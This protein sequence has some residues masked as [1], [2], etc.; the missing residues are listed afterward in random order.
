MRK[1]EAIIYISKSVVDNWKIPVTN[2]KRGV[3]AVYSD[4]VFAIIYHLIMRL[5]ISQQAAL[6][7]LERRKLVEMEVWSQ[8]TRSK[9]ISKIKKDR[10]K[11]NNRK[12]FKNLV[13]NEEGYSFQR[14]ITNDTES[15]EIYKF[16]G[17]NKPIVK[18]NKP[19]KINTATQVIKNWLSIHTKEIHTLNSFLQLG[20]DSIF[21]ILIP[22]LPY[23]AIKRGAKEVDNFEKLERVKNKHKLMPKPSQK[24]SY[25]DQQP[26]IKLTNEIRAIVIDFPYQSTDTSGE[27][28]ENHLSAVW[29]TCYKTKLNY[30]LYFEG[31]E[32][33]NSKNE[34][35]A[36]LKRTNKS[37]II[38]VTQTSGTGRRNR[39]I[40]FKAMI[41]L[42]T[43]APKK[44]SPSIDGL[45]INSIGCIINVDVLNLSLSFPFDK[46]VSGISAKEATQNLG[47][48]FNWINRYAN[49][50]DELYSYYHQL[51]PSE[52]TKYNAMPEFKDNPFTVFKRNPFVLPLSLK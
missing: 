1:K 50:E 20:D 6:Q 38:N 28:Q 24:N 46:N 37:L 10:N 22:H 25:I 39:E 45:P 13:I 40:S 36:L 11:K 34:Y 8:A 30:L 48:W 18:I 5:N 14:T 51:S 52:V 26:E 4:N 29:L 47:K 44:L 2:D 23:S 15:Y 7:Q 3:N 21:N 31:T 27:L 9:R 41:S 43:I 35:S 33:L 17:D 49:L 16:Q 19:I 42:P 12:G 32:K